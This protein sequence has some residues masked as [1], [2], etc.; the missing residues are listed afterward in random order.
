MK[1]IEKSLSKKLKG[2]EYSRCLSLVLKNSIYCSEND[3][4]FYYLMDKFAEHT[5][6]LAKEQD[7]DD[8]DDD[9]DDVKGDNFTA[10]ML[11]EKRKKNRIRK[12][13]NRDNYRLL[14]YDSKFDHSILHEI[15]HQLP[16]TFNKL[17]YCFNHEYFNKLM[18][19]NYYCDKY[20]MNFKQRLSISINR[21]SIT[22]EIKEWIRLNIGVK[23]V[24]I[25][26]GDYGSI[27]HP[28]VEEYTT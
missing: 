20:G 27:I 22:D 6:S 10:V 13:E 5:I 7:D 3:E 9:Y 19:N 2:F 11:R 4:Q 12:K 15:A 26:Y 1:K 23:E 8:D 21:K 25:K 18:K 28:T 17:K 14:P 16:K 24:T